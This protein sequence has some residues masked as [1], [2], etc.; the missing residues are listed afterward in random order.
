MLQKIKQ[1]IVRGGAKL[2]LRENLDQFN[3]QL[4]GIGKARPKRIVISIE[5]EMGRSMNGTLII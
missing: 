2:R 1:S 4:E 5:G 3:C